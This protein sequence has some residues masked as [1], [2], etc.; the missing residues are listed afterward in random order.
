M[1]V[2]VVLHKFDVS[3][4]RPGP[5]FRDNIAM[6]ER[7]NEIEG[8]IACASD[9]FEET[10]YHHQQRRANVNCSYIT[11]SYSKYYYGENHGQKV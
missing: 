8:E 2:D 11:F 5:P 7:E 4:D 10:Y 1:V 6:S 9:I 3:C